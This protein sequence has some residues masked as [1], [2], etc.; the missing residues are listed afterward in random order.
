MPMER[1]KVITARH[2]LKWASRRTQAGVS[3]ADLV[4]TASWEGPDH[5]LQSLAHNVQRPSEPASSTEESLLE[6]GNWF[7]LPTLPPR[8]W[9]KGWPVP[10][11]PMTMSRGSNRHPRAPRNLQARTYTRVHSSSCSTETVH[12]SVLCHRCSSDCW[13][14]H[15]FPYP[16]K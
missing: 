15:R 13:Y 9:E 10:G 4:T 12:S 3:A 5:I 11:F 6:P 1:P 7:Y 16:K 2:T 8:E 14:P